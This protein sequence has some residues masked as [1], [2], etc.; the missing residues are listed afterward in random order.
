MK[1]PMARSPKRRTIAI[2]PGPEDCKI[3]KRRAIARCPGGA[4]LQDSETVRYL[5]IPKRRHCKIAKRLAIARSDA[6]L[7]D[8]E[9]MMS[10]QTC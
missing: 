9:A 8:S 3:P 1:Y 7:K 4:L 6:L 5:K 2:S 10:Y